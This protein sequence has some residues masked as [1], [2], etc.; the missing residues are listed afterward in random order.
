M[1][2]RRS[3]TV[4]LRLAWV[5]SDPRWLLLPVVAGGETPTLSG[6]IPG[7]LPG[8]WQSENRHFRLNSGRSAA[9]ALSSS[10]IR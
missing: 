6:F 3:G 1:V 9:L 2:R 5:L 10:H 8:S 4:W 7:L